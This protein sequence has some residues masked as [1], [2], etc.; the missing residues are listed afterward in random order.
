MRKLKLPGRDKSKPRLNETDIDHIKQLGIDEVKVQARRIINEKL[1]EEK[2]VPRGGNPVYKAMHA[3]N[4]ASRRE[5][6]GAH[7]I[8]MNRELKEKD[9]EMVVNLVMRWIV[10]EYNFYIQEE[11]EQQKSLEEFEKS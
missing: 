2:E 3:C 10:R 4:V 5:L 8:S 9:I 1:V 6:K 11:R 7:W